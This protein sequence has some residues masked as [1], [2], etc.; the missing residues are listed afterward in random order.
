M[1]PKVL[2]T[3]AL[4]ALAAADET[5]TINATSNWGTW[6]GWGVSLAWWAKA[7]GNRED[8]AD[9]FFGLDS[10]TLD[11][12]SLPGLG[13]NIARYN[14]GACSNNTYGGSSMVASP[15]IKASRQ[16]D[17]F[18]WDWASD[19]PSSSS[20]HWG[21]D[22]NQRSMLT[23]AVANGANHVVGRPVLGL[24]DSEF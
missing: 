7:F 16:M 23:K 20:W 19:D 4:V 24:R 11:S 8:L 13:F 6:E 22:P 1:F 18:W 14:A 9:V 2:I 15:D 17:G 21:V 12:Q 5:W 3:G 10:T